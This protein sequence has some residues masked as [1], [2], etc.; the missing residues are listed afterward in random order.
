MFNY[1]RVASNIEQISK[2]IILNLNIPWYR[3]VAKQIDLGIKEHK[4]TTNF[5][6]VEW[7][8]EP[9]TIPDIK[10]WAQSLLAQLLSFQE[11]GSMHKNGLIVKLVEQKESPYLK[12][13][14][15]FDDMHDE[16][17]INEEGAII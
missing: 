15:S 16:I 5:G 12:V 10:G 11:E 6:R 2:T 7:G 4:I 8:D 1:R 3:I 13:E 17:I 14:V 9:P